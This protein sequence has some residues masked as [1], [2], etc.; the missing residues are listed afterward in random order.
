[1]THQN[2]LEFVLLENLIIYRQYRP[3]GITKNCI[4]PIVDQRLDNHFRAGHFLVLAHFL[5]SL[6][7]KFNFGLCTI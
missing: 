2:V 1:M 4:Y 3:T 7:T 6:A 5:L